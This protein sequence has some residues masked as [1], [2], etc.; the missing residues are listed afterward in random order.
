MMVVIC[1]LLSITASPFLNQLTINHHLLG[2]PLLPLML[3]VCALSPQF[4]SQGS[5]VSATT[6]ASSAC[7][8]HLGKAQKFRLS[9][10]PLSFDTPSFEVFS[11]RF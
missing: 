5:L 8:L 1:F 2:D 4:L 11:H 3:S 7:I 9:I 6:S 10:L